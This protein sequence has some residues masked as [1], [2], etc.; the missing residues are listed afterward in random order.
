MTTLK[1]VAV[2]NAIEAL[3]FIKKNHLDE[4]K[5]SAIYHI[6]CLSN[7]LRENVASYFETVK[8]LS[9]KAAGKDPESDEVKGFSEEL[10]KLQQREITFDFEKIS[11]AAT[12]GEIKLNAMEGMNNGQPVS[13]HPLDFLNDFIVA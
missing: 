10:A 4:L 13:V 11:I 5:A 3:A 9:S 6:N 2:L 12:I 8:E 1:I 7:S